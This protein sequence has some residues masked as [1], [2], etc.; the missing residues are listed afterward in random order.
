MG[1]DMLS[2]STDGLSPRWKLIMIAFRFPVS[3]ALAP[4]RFFASPS[5]VALQVVRFGPCAWFEIGGP[6]ITNSRYI[7]AGD[8]RSLP[9]APTPTSHSTVGAVER[10]HLWYTCP[11]DLEDRPESAVGFPPPSD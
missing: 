6:K 2:T 1:F 4:H 7:I 11:G 10:Q 9:R 3:N 5:T 8:S